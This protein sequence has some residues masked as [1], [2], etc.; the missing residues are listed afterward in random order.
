MPEM[1]EILDSE[2]E[3]SDDKNIPTGPRGEKYLFHV[4][5]YDSG[6]ESDLEEEG[7]DGDDEAEIENEAALL[8][9]S[10]ALSKAQEI[11]TL[12]AR[13][14]EQGAK[15]PKY[16]TGNLKRSERCH[17]CAW[18]DLVA[19]GQSLIESWCTEPKKVV[20]KVSNIGS[21]SIAIH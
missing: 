10:A 3:A 14:K 9:F 19:G 5:D 1:D 2:A 13:S 15:R 12:S 21:I 16:Y 17:K 20:P 18:K 4:V 11:A 8:K 7:T 6:D